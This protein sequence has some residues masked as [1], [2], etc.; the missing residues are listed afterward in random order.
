M[1][2]NKEINHI[3]WK[4][5]QLKYITLVIMYYQMYIIDSQKPKIN[6]F[7]KIYIN[8]VFVFGLQ[9]IKTS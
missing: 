2:L 8:D 9:N 5:I 6:N 7:Q 4:S 3:F 1:P